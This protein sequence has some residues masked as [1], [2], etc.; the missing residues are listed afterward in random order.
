MLL[1]Q[2]RCRGYYPQNCKGLPCQWLMAVF[3]GNSYMSMI[4]LVMKLDIV[5]VS[6]MEVIAD[7][8]GLIPAEF[9]AVHGSAFRGGMA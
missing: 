5:G 2:L 6:E 3:M 4:L 8:S 9:A 7:F 1:L